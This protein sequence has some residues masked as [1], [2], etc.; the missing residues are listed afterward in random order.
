M[1]KKKTQRKFTQR[2][3]V[4]VLDW[5]DLSSFF[6]LFSSF[7]IFYDVVIL[8][9]YGRNYLKKYVKS[10]PQCIGIVERGSTVFVENKIMVINNK[11]TLIKINNIKR[12]SLGEND[13]MIS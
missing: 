8:H 4:F 6:F 2:L 9:P 7:Y 11:R 3:T 1:H 12:N 13:V 5:W 10:Y